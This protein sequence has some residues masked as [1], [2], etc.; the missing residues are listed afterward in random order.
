[1]IVG[2]I[3][4]YGDNLCPKHALSR[5]LDGD[6]NLLPVFQTEEFFE[7]QYCSVCGKEIAV[8]VTDIDIEYPH[9]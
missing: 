3:D 1:M 8:T 4:I 6:K 7:K 5:F 9:N 2:Y